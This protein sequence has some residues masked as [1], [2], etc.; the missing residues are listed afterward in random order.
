MILMK[1]FSILLLT[2]TL[3][4]CWKLLHRMDK[5]PAEVLNKEIQLAAAQSGHTDICGLLLAHGSDVNEVHPESKWTAL[6]HAAA[7]GHK[8]V[9]EALFYWGAIVDPQNHLVR[10]P[11]IAAAVASC[12]HTAA[13]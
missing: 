10:T 9:V 2:E 11:L 7:R 8:A 5:L 12:W 3:K 1:S 6:H 4:G 13:M